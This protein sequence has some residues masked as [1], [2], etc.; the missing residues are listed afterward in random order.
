M[1]DV[2][3]SPSQA[4]GDTIYTSGQ[5]GIDPATGGVPPGFEEQVQHALD[6]LERVLA[7]AGATLADVV[8]TTV[9]LVD[10]AYFVRMNAVYAER[11]VSHRPAR[12]TLICGLAQPGLLIEIEAVAR[13]AA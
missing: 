2:P 1:T 6:A 7:D 8:K 4:I 9:V 11:F 5:V 12:T 13:R 10:A 3:L